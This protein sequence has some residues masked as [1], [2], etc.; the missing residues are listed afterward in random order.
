MSSAPRGGNAS[1]SYC[2]ENKRAEKRK[3]EN[4]RAEKLRILRLT[5]RTAE[6]KTYCSFFAHLSVPPSMRKALNTCSRTFSD[7]SYCLFR[8]E[9]TS[10]C[11]ESELSTY[12]TIILYKNTDKNVCKPLNCASYFY[13]ISYFQHS[14]FIIHTFDIRHCTAPSRH[15]HTHK[16]TKDLFL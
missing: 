3:A 13:L 12:Y 10:C 2:S 8:L 4:F 15:T 16:N 5:V 11:T 7:Y 6:R 1:Y 14:Q 9:F